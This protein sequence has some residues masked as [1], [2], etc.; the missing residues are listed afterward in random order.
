MLK[1]KNNF[2]DPGLIWRL[3]LPLLFLIA[4]LTIP[5]EAWAREK[6]ISKIRVEGNRRLSRD[7]VLARIRIRS[8]NP[9]IP[10]DLNADLQR[11]HEWGPFAAIR[12]EA[13]ESDEDEMTVV[14][15]VEEKPI[16]G[17][18]YFEGNRHFKDKKLRKEILTVA[19]DLLSETRL[20][21]DIQLL[22]DLYVKDRFYQTRINYRIK[23]N[24]AAGE[25][26][27][28][29]NIK[30]G[31]QVRVKKI[32]L[33]G[34]SLLTAKELRKA[35]STRPHSLFS[36]IRRGKFSEDEFNLD[37]ERIA[38]YARSQGYL[39]FKV[40]D[41]EVK[42]GEDGVG[43]FINIDVS[44]GERY[45]TGEIRVVGNDNYSA[46]DLEPLLSLK[47]PLP[48][49]P[50][51][52]RKDAGSLKDFYYERGYIDVAVTPRQILNPQTG[53]IDVTYQISENRISYIHRID[54]IG[55]QITRDRVIRRELLVKP[56]E[57][58]NGV[59]VQRSQQRLENLGFFQ[60]VSI[61]PLPTS[62]PEKK[63][64]VIR[65]EEKKT[66]EFMFGVG[67]SSEDDFIGFVEI[68]QGN[69]DLFKPPLFMGAG[70]KM[71]IRAEF[72]SSKSNYEMSFVEPWLFGVPLSFGID[73]YRRTRYWNEYD[74][75][76][77][78]GNL[79][80]RRLLTT[81]TQIGL[82]Y[83]LENIEI[84]NV[85]NYADWS[86]QSE[87]GKNWVS[88]ITPSITRDTRDSFLV[89]NRGMRATL[90][91]QLAGGI[92][93]GDKDF[94]KTTFNGSYYLSI[95]PG[96]ILGFRFRAGTAQPYSDTENVPAYERFY[97]GGANT[98]R[99]FRYREVG[100]QGI[101]PRTGQPNSEPVGGDSMMMASV[102]YT[103]PIIEMVRGA[104]FYDVGNVWSD[105]DWEL[106]DRIFSGDWFK[107][108]NSGAGFGLRLYLPIG[109]IKLDYG[110]PL[111][112]DG[113]NDT[114]GRFHFNIGYA[115]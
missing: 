99:G 49:S 80:L 110:W 72:G 45:Y 91:C 89:P 21:E 68:G 100:P 10:E 67:Y 53:R 90:A 85:D 32:S 1:P 115:F 84:Y 93:G 77:L 12:I 113:W 101:D 19:G 11:L 76:R 97:L 6:T 60:Q 16:V 63:D 74:E 55:N 92:L 75:K 94:I 18:I 106:E 44:E 50:E 2:P 14:I 23:T 71:K 105:K 15:T 114:G 83:N 31:Y 81:F 41:S 108:L 52:M 87:A 104:F 8:G 17:K 96:H 29:I 47:D 56:G 27:V 59:R 69:F 66:G 13:E 30:E 22:Y 28:F 102:E 20:N 58:F 111:T 3:L 57:I 88:S 112:T 7:A 37:L 79:R 39:D 86:I 82:N 95:F 43:L 42:V 62:A 70:Q 33:S 9:F 107:S 5:P 109:P 103:F 54:I 38:L 61:E 78:G 46:A 34:L 40:V 24:P 48:Y 73:I 36:I 64:L 25:A 35:M 51:T 98:I 4:A 65:L 26:E